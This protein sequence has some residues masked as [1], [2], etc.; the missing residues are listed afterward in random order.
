[1]QGLYIHLFRHRRAGDLIERLGVK[2]ARD[3]LQHANESTTVTVY[4]AHAGNVSRK[5]VRT[6]GDID[7]LAAEQVAA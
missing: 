2:V 4:G 6:H 1:M 3:H 5:L 7:T